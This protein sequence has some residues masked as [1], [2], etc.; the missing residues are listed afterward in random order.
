MSIPKS[1]YESVKEIIDSV[2]E[3]GYTT[4]AEFCK[5]AIRRRISSI[6]KEYQIGKNDVEYIVAEITRTMKSNEDYKSILDSVNY[7]I[8]VFSNPD[9]AL[10]TSNRKFLEILG[11]SED[12]VKGK[13]FSE[14]VVPD[15]V[16]R[17]K[18]RFGERIKGK[19]GEDKCVV[20]AL[21]RNGGIVSIEVDCDLYKVGDNVKGVCV[22]IR[23]GDEE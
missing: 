17:V 3:L 16:P 20:K 7:G 23:K 10:I 1:L 9:G 13:R 19:D 4:P 2:P 15:D 11:Y 5:D 12:D 8:A 21:D 22:L 14:F 18:R 6:K